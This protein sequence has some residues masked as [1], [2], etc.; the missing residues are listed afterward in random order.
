MANNEEREPLPVWL[1]GW[2]DK[3]LHRTMALACTMMRRVAA[4]LREHKPNSQQW[5]AHA[6]EIDGAAEILAGWMLG[7]RIEAAQETEEKRHG[8]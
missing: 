1:L 4:S 6:A 3:A 2:Q 7:L 8:Q 5:L